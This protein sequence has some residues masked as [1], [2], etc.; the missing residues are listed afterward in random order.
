[1]ETRPPSAGQIA[2]AAGFAI[3]CFGLLL[4][5]WLSFGGPVPLAPKS[6]RI[7]VPFTEATNLAV[8]S[9]V[10]I[11]GV[12]VGKVKGIELGEDGVAEATVEL[13]ERYSPVATD[14][15]AILRQKTLLGETYVELTPGSPDGATIPE[16][17]KL[18]PAQISDAV[19]LDEIFRAFDDRTRAAFQAWMRDGAVSF[20]DRGVDLNAAFGNLALFALEA[21]RTLVVLDSERRSLRRLVGA[22][23]EVFEALSRTGQLSGLVTNA[24][25]VFSTTAA[26]DAELEAAF[27][28]L[29][30]FLD[31]TRLTLE[32]LDR[33][34]ADTNPLVTQLR[35]AARELGP[36]ARQLELLA[37]ELRGAMDGLLPVA[38]RAGNLKSLRQLLDDDLPPLLERLDPFLVQLN[39]PLESLRDYRREVT[40]FLANVGSATNAFNRPAEGDFEEVHY[41]RTTS[42]LS[43]DVLAGFPARLKS[44]RTNPYVQPSGYTEL[45]RGLESFSTGQCSG[46]ITAKLDPSDSGDFPDDLFDRIKLY[47]YGDVLNSDNVPAPRCTKQSP[48]GSLGGSSEE[49]TDYLHIRADP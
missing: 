34:A 36:T 8:E 47:A 38:K 49:F 43:P 22:G 21:N 6:Y 31:E 5:L 30:T 10:R 15:K 41:L 46:G 44:N 37:P 3:S 4:F 32:R 17:G 13:E 12:T 35:P 28:A 7:T 14:T 33:F 27:R 20:G 48:F 42:P 40:A 2:L 9:D 39:P 18:D 19:Q 24:E 1:M 16:G 11:S 29:P 23:G 45:T 26:R 25:A